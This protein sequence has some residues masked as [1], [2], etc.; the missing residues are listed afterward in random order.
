MKALFPGHRGRR[1]CP[2][3]RQF[4]LRQPERKEFIAAL[5]DLIPQVTASPRLL[6]GAGMRPHMGASAGG[7]AEN[8]GI[9][10]WGRMYVI[11]RHPN[12]L[13]QNIKR[14][15]SLVSSCIRGVSLRFVHAKARSSDEWSAG[16]KGACYT[17]TSMLLAVTVGFG[18]GI[19]SSMRPFI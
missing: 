1:T 11:L 2:G 17:A 7:A 19:L 16:P 4:R 8:A 15:S 10:K 3:F 13:Q 18:M 9:G 12:S 5:K 6:A 14:T